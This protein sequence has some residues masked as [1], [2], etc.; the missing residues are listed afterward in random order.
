MKEEIHA[1]K[2]KKVLLPS[3]QV[4]YNILTNEKF[5][6]SLFQNYD[7]VPS[8]MVDSPKFNIFI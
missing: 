4:D 1:E 5:N 3:N 7:K 2:L 6:E 8:K